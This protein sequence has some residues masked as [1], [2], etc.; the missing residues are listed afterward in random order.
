MAVLQPGIR[1]TA[2]ITA[3]DTRLTS[4]SVL[5]PVY[6]EQYM[7]TASL[8]RLEVL[9]ESP[10]LARIQVIVVDNGSTDRTPEVL[11]EF[12]ATL[13]ESF[14]RGKFDWKFVRLEKN[15]RKGGAVQYAAKIAECDL[16]I[17]HDA[18][19]EYHPS[20]L[21]RMV[22]LLVEEDADAVLGS[23]F[24]GS[25]ARPLLALRHRVGNRV[26][27][28]LGAIGSDADFTDVAT[29]YRMVRRDLFNSIP[30][31]FDDYGMDYELS[32][33]LA[34]R[35]ARIF[36]VPIRYSGRT[37][38]QGKKMRYA[39]ATW[40]CF[41]SIVRSSLTDDLYAPDEFRSHLTSRVH[42]APRLAG[43]VARLIRPHVGKH[44]LELG[45]GIGNL[46]LLLTPRERYRS[47]EINPVYLQ[48]LRRLTFGAPYL[49]A[50]R[51]D[52][53]RRETYPEEQFD[54]VICRYQLENADDEDAIL[55][56]LRDALKPGGK[57]IILV[58]NKPSLYGTWDRI[59]GHRRRYTA[60]D[61]TAKCERAGLKKVEVKGFNR[62]SS[63]A[64]WWNS[65]A[66]GSERIGTA[67]IRL[68]NVFAGL[69]ERVDPYL[70]LPPL[71]LI[72]V[73][74]KTGE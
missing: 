23:R 40:R 4:L 53:T 56:N 43:W 64:W 6:N 48:A 10:Y 19:L 26:M 22:P 33:K 35:K 20:D 18:D 15:V 11:R 67:Q 66:L 2:Q 12:Q 25:E 29:C 69:L 62:L 47:A 65:K 14:G 41:Y 58:P 5:V 21:L 17:T 60:E 27:S 7:V 72:G 71:S 63:V 1:S 44:V 38:Q 37:V 46:T 24:A 59:L 57:A 55:R 34:R 74:E 70:P 68:F 13:D 52:A 49:E 36:E 30:Y 39:S 31:F 32:V 16:V 9:A 50:L 42:H 54:T 73:F 3:S 45:A 28:L 61:L 8:R 51:V